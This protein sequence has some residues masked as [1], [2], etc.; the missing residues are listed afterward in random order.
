MSKV[1]VEDLKS[2]TYSPNTDMVQDLRYVHLTYSGKLL[3]K[4][5]SGEQ[6]EF[7]LILIHAEDQ[8]ASTEMAKVMAKEIIELYQKK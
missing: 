4:E 3:V 5:A 2:L 7:A 8:M 1:K 6:L